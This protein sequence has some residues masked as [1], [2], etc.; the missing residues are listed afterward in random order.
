MKRLTVLFTFALCTAVSAPAFA[1]R[2]HVGVY[3]GVPFNLFYYPPVY[4]TPYGYCA[5]YFCPPVVV[6]PPVVVQP[7]PVPAPAQAQPAQPSQGTWYYCKGADKY[8]PYVQEC[9]GGWE[10]VPATPPR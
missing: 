1:G 2:T 4:V 9:P 3:F 5:G 7:V 6:A 10:H 8:Y